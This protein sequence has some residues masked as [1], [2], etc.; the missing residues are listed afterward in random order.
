MISFQEAKKQVLSRVKSIQ[1]REAV[2]PVN[3]LGRV[4]SHSV[5]A[6]L[7]VPNHDNSAMDGYAM[8]FS[9]LHSSQPATFQVIADLPAGDI[10][11][12][13]VNKGEAIRIMT[14]APIPPGCDTVVMQEVVERSGQQITIPGGQKQHQHIRRA[15]E[16][17]EKGSKV[18]PAGYRLKAADLGL[19]T[20]LGVAEISV[21]RRPVVALL[22]SG[23]E[24]I[25]AGV[26]IK[27]GQ[28]YDSNRTTLHTALTALGVEVLDLG[29][30]RDN[31]SDIKRALH[32]GGEEADAIISTGGVSVGDDDLIKEV[33]QEWGD[34]H[35]WKVAM[36]PG[37]PQAYGQL[38][39]AIF[40]GLPG[41][42][43]SGL[44]VFLTIVRPALIRLM[45]AQDEPLPILTMPFRGTLRKKHSR[46]D[47]VRGIV[48]YDAE[49]PWV[50]TTGPQGS[51]ILT[52][53]SKANAFI[54]LPEAP[55]TLKDGDPV[56]VQ[57]IQ[58]H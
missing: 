12:D 36:K 49:G 35:F 44:T 50:E 54:V 27:P 33:L 42:P 19:L 28:V 43:V 29:V 53:L 52:S 8:A 5:L 48:H 46:M 41:N 45:G 39:N 4:L 11:T 7:N 34:I 40:F 21:F 9:D 17:I 20:S 57:L 1:E 38:G 10:I 47:F 15:G 24:V 30:V 22:S 16:D 31:R 2:S 26:D 25:E 32:R 3:G 51:G 58:Y 37:K 13:P 23:N 56:V 55:T 6:P 18:L 14:G